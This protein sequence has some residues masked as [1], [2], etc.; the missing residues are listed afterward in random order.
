VFSFDWIGDTLVFGNGPSIWTIEF[1]HGSPQPSELRKIASGTTAMVDVRGFASKLVFESRTAA[2]HLWSL[3]LDLNSGKVLGPLQ[4][5]RHAGGSQTLPASSSDGR[6]LAYLQPAFSPDGSKILFRSERNG[7]GIYGI[8]ALGGEERL[9]APRGRRPQFS[10]DGTQIAYYQAVLKISGHGRARGVI[11]LTFSNGGTPRELSPRFR[12]ARSPVWSPDG[13]HLLFLGFRDEQSK[14]KGG[15]W[16]ADQ[17]DWWIVSLDGK[18]TVRTGALEL[19]GR[20]G[21]ALDEGEP[22]EWVATA[23][24]D[25]ILFSATIGETTNIWE[26][27]IS[28][29]TWQVTGSPRRLTSGTATETYPLLSARGL[30]FAGLSSNSDIWSLPIDAQRGKPLG[31]LQP[32]VQGGAEDIHSSLSRDGRTLAFNSGRS[33]YPDIWVKDL[34]TGKESAVTEGPENETRVLISPDGSKVAYM[35]QKDGLVNFHLAGLGQGTS[36]RL[37]ENCG[38]NMLDWS[39]TGNELLY[40]WGNPIRFSLLDISSHRS[41]IVLQH[42][43]YDLHRG[44]ISPDGSWLA[45]G[46]PKDPDNFLVFVAPLRQGLPPKETEWISVAS[47]AGCPH[48]SPDGN[49]LYFLSARDGFLCLWAQNLDPLAKRP[50]GLPFDVYHFHNARQSL[51]SAWFG[52]IG[53]SVARSQLVF[54]MKEMTGNIWM[55]E[56]ER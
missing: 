22:G 40:W 56:M 32:L 1:K 47:D 27:A 4:P 42:P 21:L 6:W 9:I 24:G 37:C 30:V 51:N 38:G 53:M 45:F 25:A 49:L 33:G 34:A 55:K 2:C 28:N 8:S 29:K 23:D 52:T 50:S 14:S 18:L 19:L 15:Q 11:Y 46:V 26:V 43:E 10:P 3:P 17:T 7:G 48:W 16:L 13:K 12:V 39:P 41:Q 44:Q 54:S 20:H 5:L 35:V 36:E 31:S